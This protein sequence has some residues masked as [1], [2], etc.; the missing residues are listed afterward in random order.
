MTDRL[1]NQIQIVQIQT[2]SVAQTQFVLGVQ[3]THY[4][5]LSD[6][7]KLTNTNSATEAPTNLISVPLCTCT[8]IFSTITLAIC[9]RVRNET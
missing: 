8:I 6:G 4:L 2:V 7:C 3:L 5:T 9:S 1:K